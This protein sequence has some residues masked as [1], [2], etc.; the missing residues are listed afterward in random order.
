MAH[1]IYS[2]PSNSTSPLYLNGNGDES[3]LIPFD[4]LSSNTFYIRVAMSD[5]TYPSTSGT[6]PSIYL[7]TDGGGEVELST[8][9]TSLYYGSGS[10]SGTK[11]ADVSMESE[12]HD[13]FLVEIIMDQVI[14][15]TLYIKIYNNDSQ[16][17]YFIWVVAD[18]LLE[19]EQPWIHVSPELNFDT[20]I[21]TGQTIYDTLIIANRG[22]GP[23][24]INESLG[25]IQVPD[26]DNPNGSP[27]DSNYEIT[28]LPGEIQ[29][30]SYG[31]LGI[32]FN[33]PASPS[34]STTIY[35]IGSLDSEA[36]SDPTTLH[37][38]QVELH[39]ICGKLE[40][41]FLLDTSGSMAW[42]PTGSSP[43]PNPEESRWGRLK[44]AADDSLILLGEYG[45][46]VGRFAI[47]MF[48]DITQ[49][50]YP[51]NPAPPISAEDFYP[52]SDITFAN[53]D[54][55]RNSLDDHTPADHKGATPMGKGIEYV[56]VGTNG[57]SHFEG[58][59][60]SVLYNQRLLV[61]MSDGAHNSGPPVPS[62]FYRTS[63]GGTECVGEGTAAEEDQSLLEKGIRVVTVAYGQ[64][65]GLDVIHET[66]ETLACKSKSGGEDLIANVEP[67]PDDI[68]PLAKTMWGAIITGLNLE[69]ASDP[70]GLLTA[71][72]PEVRAPIQITPYDSK[73]SLLVNWN[74]FDENRVDVQLLTPTCDFIT[75][76]TAQNDPD[77]TY[78]SH[79]RGKLFTI[80]SKYFRNVSNPK[81]PRYGAWKLIIS[82]NDLEE[83]ES[84][85][86]Q[87]GVIM[88]SRLKLKLSL[89]K[90]HYYAGDPI[91]LTAT[92][93]L[94]GKP[95][96]GAA[97]SLHL[98]TPVQS[99]IN[100]LAK[101]KVTTAEYAKSAALLKDADITPL[102][103]KS[104]AIHLKGL[105][106]DNL[107]NSS[108]I[109]MLDEHNQ[110]HYNATIRTTSVTGIYKL[111]V[112]VIGQTS[113][114]EI[115]QREIQRDVR[116][117][118]RPDPDYTLI[119]AVYTRVVEDE[120]IFYR[121]DVRV[122]PRDSFG[123]MVLVDPEFSPAV[124]L[125]A[126]EGEPSGPLVGNL[127]GSYS[128]TF[129][130]AAD[131]KM[132]FDLHV[133]G[134]SIIENRRSLSVAHLHYADQ[135]LAFEPGPADNEQINEH[136]NLEDALGDVTTKQEGQFV[137]LGI[138][139]SLALGVRDQAILA[140]SG[141]DVIVFV[142]SDDELHPYQVEALPVYSKDQW[143]ELGRSQ[144]VT[145]AFSLGKAGLKSVKA[146][147]INDR[148]SRGNSESDIGN[149]VRLLGLGF[150]KVG[151]LHEHTN[152]CLM[153]P[154]NILKRLL[155]RI[156]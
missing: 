96:R 15:D 92:I 21:L 102:G 79:P 35:I 37:N 129:R 46:G 54:A 123:N 14:P 28:S 135:I 106:F 101:T 10:L 67:D 65:P 144:G 40:L 39:A 4:V 81:E 50:D 38:N 63:E 126:K 124:Q 51:T 155:D 57:I 116:V 56:V 148:S 112:R 143:I 147:R 110:G 78:H 71:D 133:N 151:S 55:A 98:T 48:P 127:D 5:P 117:G 29:A 88:E 44:S 153:I 156:K 66:L 16:P 42:T 43:P 13:L 95:L 150:E 7:L 122:W 140:G 19:T 109:P 34:E 18:N 113:N 72:T 87:Y 120:R 73:V 31:D 22:T 1:D 26:P 86:Y 77:I 62:D 25:A 61:L 89:N 84:E 146:I 115:Y 53:I 90:T 85:P 107:R 134:K 70:T 9:S 136:R 93:T 64:E 128:R 119:D 105:A 2:D 33:A 23:L 121:V 74:A 83:G 6:D 132:T 41:M 60:E 45:N 154:I 12:D 52:P 36:V 131:A 108:T 141:E 80:G 59:P 32:C 100:W 49:P 118:A 97:A 47:S 3:P 76:E 137:N 130:S 27:I 139:G 30:N 58:S 24:T 104:H 91:E 94:D 138:F 152:G 142:K 68:D 17:R 114:D 75:P 149:G 103:I 125:S 20:G 99:A 82:G 11:V 111:R 69:V 145:S 8:S